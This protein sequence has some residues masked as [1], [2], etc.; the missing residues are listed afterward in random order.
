MIPVSGVW[1]EI[2]VILVKIKPLV[3]LSSGCG[4]RWGERDVT[5][6]APKVKLLHNS[7]YSSVPS[8]WRQKGERILAPKVE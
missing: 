7:G 3:L 1:R 2:P 4:N 6:F 5:R 8:I